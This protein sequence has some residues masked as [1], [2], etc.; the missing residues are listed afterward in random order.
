MVCMTDKESKAERYARTRATLLAEARAIFSSQ[1]FAG[2]G[3]EAIVRAAEVTRGALYYHFADKQALFEAVIAEESRL[4]LE[5]LLAQSAD[6]KD[7]FEALAF[8]CF[9]Y[10]QA[11]LEPGTRRIYLIDGPAVLGWSRWRE[12]DDHFS[13]AELR[14]RVELLLEECTGHRDPEIVT[15]LISGAISEAVLWLSET[16]DPDDYARV[17]DTLG[18][19][20]RSIF[21]VPERFDEEPTLKI[22]PPKPAA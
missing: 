9:A 13:G 11:C 18:E 19:M 21:A 4:V 8:A 17:E 5:S 2:A 15:L 12:I 3:T 16:D 14:R 10:I 20:L 6:A 22:P 1:G 7:R